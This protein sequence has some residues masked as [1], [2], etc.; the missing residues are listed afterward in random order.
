M[1]VRAA[2]AIGLKEK[3]QGIAL[4]KTFAISRSSYTRWTR[5]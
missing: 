1:K 3:E 4:L 5:L 2:Y